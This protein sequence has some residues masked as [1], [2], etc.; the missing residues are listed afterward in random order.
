VENGIL[1]RR[2]VELGEKLLDGRIEVRTSLPDHVSLVVAGASLQ[3]G[4]K[5]LV[6]S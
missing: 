2:R 3:A 1:Q 6:R 4:R 5:A